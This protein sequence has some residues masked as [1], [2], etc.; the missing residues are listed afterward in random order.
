MPAVPTISCVEE[1]ASLATV[2]TSIIRCYTY[3]PL[4]ASA[5]WPRLSPDRELTAEAMSLLMRLDSKLRYARADWNEDRFR[6]LMRARAKAV[7]RLRRRWERLTPQP[8]I[9]LGSLRRRYHAN[10]AAHLNSVS[11][12]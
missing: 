12:D 8:R 6:R 10:I 2:R 9:T 11:Q 7:V 4:T 5:L 3:P 1:V